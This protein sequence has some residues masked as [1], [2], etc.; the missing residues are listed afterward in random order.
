M[1]T[2]SN[3]KEVGEEFT[4]EW[5]YSASG[6][7]TG[8]LYSFAITLRDC[9]SDGS[10]CSSGSACGSEY[11]SLCV[12]DGG[13]CMDSDGSYDVQIPEDAPAGKY[14]IRVSLTEDTTVF[15]CT[16]AFDV[17]EPDSS[18]WDPDEPSLEVIAPDYVE[19]GSPF[20]AQWIYDDGAGQAGGTFEVSLYACDGGDCDDGG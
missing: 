20:T 2:P 19:A 11:V 10:D 16:D 5:S 9:G 17:T 15:S 13:V 14:G 7:T 8:D 1:V 12:L 18:A 6:G 3:S 4:V